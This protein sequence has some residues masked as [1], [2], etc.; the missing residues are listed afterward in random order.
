MRNGKQRQREGGEEEA[1]KH[2][3][4]LT[5]LPGV[6]AHG[7]ALALRVALISSEEW[8]LELTDA[9]WRY[10]KKKKIGHFRN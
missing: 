3:Q 7:R 5:P 6:Y 10:E 4:A 2:V 1:W 8:T 9:S